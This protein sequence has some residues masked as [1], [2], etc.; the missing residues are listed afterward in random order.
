VL[1]DGGWWEGKSL[2]FCVARVLRTV[3]QGVRNANKPLYG[4]VAVW[5]HLEKVLWSDKRTP[6]CSSFRIA[7]RVYQGF[8]YFE[9]R[10]TISHFHNHKFFPWLTKEPHTRAANVPPNLSISSL[11]PLFFSPSHLLNIPKG[12]FLIG[13]FLI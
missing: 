8:D 2:W 12:S 4:I 10:I 5:Q 13:C 7:E 9:R 11:F 6:P 3:L 1:L